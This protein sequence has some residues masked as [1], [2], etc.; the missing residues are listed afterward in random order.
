MP[1]EKAKPNKSQKKPLEFLGKG[2]AILWL[3]ALVGCSPPNP[4]KA[5]LVLGNPSNATTD[6]ANQT[7]YLI[8]RP[9]YALSYNTKNG[10]PNWVSW[11]LNKS[12]LGSAD[13]QD[14]FRGDESL[15]EGWYKVS[16]KDYTNSGYDRGHMT[17]SADRTRSVADNS[18]TFVMTNI[19]PQTADNNRGPWKYLEE[20]SRDL[21]AEGKELY[22]I[23]GPDGSQKRI[24]DRKVL[25][26]WRTWKIIVVLDRPGSGVRGIT[27]KTRV[28][29]VII[30]NTKNLK[31]KDWKKYRVSVDEVEKETNYDFL[32]NVPKS[33]QDEIERRV[34]DQ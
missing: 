4:S 3:L 19:V 16:P 18:A 5:H 1:P 11:Q 21:V 22:I 27:A 15:P 9:Q 12:W 17:P 6:P 10:T 14:D 28:I 23:A 13:R 33:I 29:S 7:N 31:N 20:Y 24:G 25:A 8:E 32:S 30:P 2:A 34:D 26:P